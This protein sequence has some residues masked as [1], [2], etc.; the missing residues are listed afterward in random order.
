MFPLVVRHY[1]YHGYNFI[2]SPSGVSIPSA[3][4]SIYDIINNTLL[5]L[6]ILYQQHLRHSQYDSFFNT[7]PSSFVSIS[8]THFHSLRTSLP[9]TRMLT[10]FSPFQ[11]H[12][13]SLLS[14]SL[15]RLWGL[16]QY[17]PHNLVSKKT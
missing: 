14:L 12:C 16:Q 10:L 7:S 13:V 1:N 5:V 17:S 8:T 6:Y 4:C 2:P 11:W 3:P 9:I 15:F